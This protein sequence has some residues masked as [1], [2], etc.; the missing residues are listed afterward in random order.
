[1]FELSVATFRERWQLFLGA[2]VTVALGVALVQS[3]L[4]ILLSALDHVEAITLLAMTLG[5][6]AFLA[7]FIVSSTFAFT[8]A[9]RRRDLALLRLIGG[10]RGQ[11][12]RLLLSEALLLGLIGTALGI[13]AGMGVMGLQSRILTGLEFLPAA[14]SPEWQGWIIGVSAGVGVGVSLFGVL[15]ASRRAA[16]VR[17]LEALR[18]S[19]EAARVMTFSRWFFGILF[20]AGAV[21]L[22]IVAVFAGASAAIPLSVNSA[23][24]AAVGLSALSPLLVPLAS[25]VFGLVLGRGTLGTLARANLAD[26]VRRSASTAAPLLVLVALVVGLSGTLSTLTAAGRQEMVRDLDAD[27]VAASAP[28]RPVPGV[29]VAST[30]TTVPVVVAFDKSG[31]RKVKE[32]QALVV[33][34]GD[35][36]RTHREAPVAGSF[37]DLH[38]MA[39]A[40]REAALGDAITVRIGDREFGTRVVAVLPDSFVGGPGYLL[41]RDLVP[42][43]LLGNAPAHT[44]VKLAPGAD[45]AKVAAS[46][47]GPV[48]TVGDWI[49]T[50]S[51]KQEKTSSGIMTV[52]MGL[53]GL[54]SVIAVI[55]AVVIAAAERRR[56]FA[57]VRVTGLKRRQVVVMALVES[58]AVVVIALLLGLAA[59]SAALT[60]ITRATGRILGTATLSLPWATLGLVVLGA[61]T[62]VG[63][64]SVWTSISATRQAPVGLLG[65]R[66]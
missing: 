58:L 38:G 44:I 13:P 34:A 53:A 46:L 16:K 20:V 22:A 21:A 39:V 59:A 54:Y 19:G 15:A 37:D 52:L 27:L 1:M 41:P 47:P 14:F 36:R 43:S 25:R 60:G 4:L 31:K 30:E 29:A 9:Q 28:A 45:P 65:A 11:V 24:T 12:R 23:V 26:G 5:I 61:F 51:S 57:V 6:A 18:E 17:P 49:A 3:S 64:T 2:I 35:Y 48:T 8:I 10:S 40:A 50:G 55:N 7:V 32:K 62:V 33:D 42:S 66:E 56:E 63:L